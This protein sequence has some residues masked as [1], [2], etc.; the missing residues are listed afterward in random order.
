[1]SSFLMI[2]L[3]LYTR[4]QAR[5][6]RITDEQTWFIRRWGKF[7]VY[8]LVRMF[9]SWS[10]CIY[11]GQNVYILVRMFYPGQNVHILVRMFIS[12]SECFILVRMFISW[13]ECLYPGQ[14]GQ[15]VVI[16]KLLQTKLITTQSFNAILPDLPNS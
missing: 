11:P 15:N 14:N 4:L 10:K 13:L 5:Y 12:L 8:V 16:L 3:P 9:I 6:Q 1:M 2:S 7:A